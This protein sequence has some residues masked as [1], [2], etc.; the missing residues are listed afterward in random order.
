MNGPLIGQPAGSS[1]QWINA[2]PDVLTD[3]IKIEDGAL[4][5]Q[6]VT[7]GGRWAVI[8]IPTQKG[9][10]SVT[11][12]WQYVGLETG[13]VDVGICLSDKLNFELVDGNPV[14]NYNEHGTMI[15]MYSAGLVDVR[16]GDWEGGGT[17]AALAE[18]K[19]QDGVRFSI[20][21]EVDAAGWTFDAFFKK[22]GDATET[23]I[24]DDY[25]FRRLPTAES[26]GTNCLVIW[27][28][29]VA[30]TLGNGVI[31]DNFLIY[32]PDGPSIPVSV[33]DWALF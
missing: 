15:R 24:A 18:L 26:D 28:N 13:S 6:D 1:A 32:G 4:V 23:M 31:L 2:N 7:A 8:D 29:A 14:P 30:A 10:F 19:Y 11:W 9:I 16:D 25:G 12:D 3:D 20:R 33:S 22:E 21:L 5:I 27:D 17:Y